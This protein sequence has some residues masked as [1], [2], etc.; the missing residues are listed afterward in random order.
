MCV[1]DCLAYADSMYVYVFICCSVHESWNA[2]FKALRA[3][4]AP[5]DAF[6]PPPAPGQPLPTSGHAAAPTKS[7]SAG[8]GYFNQR[9]MHITRA[10]QVR[11]HE[12]AQL[13]PLGTTDRLGGQRFCAFVVVV[14]ESR[15][16][17]HRLL[18]LTCTSPCRRLQ[19]L[20]MHRNWT[21]QRTDSTKRSWTSR[22]SW[23]VCACV[24][25]TLKVRLCA[26]VPH[27]SLLVQPRQVCPPCMVS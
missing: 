5:G 23:R 13:D 14:A 20:M 2:Y 26:G 16:R 9:V 27:F 22:S 18:C 25:N 1:L 15:A 21:R 8:E 24:C 3:G 17:A 4:V 6:T 11:G 19:L 10:Y 7:V 12:R